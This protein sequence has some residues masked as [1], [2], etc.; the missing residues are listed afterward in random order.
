MSPLPVP[1][2]LD[3]GP[4]SRNNLHKVGIDRLQ[5]STTL[6][7]CCLSALRA[8]HHKRW[9]WGKIFEA[10]PE[11]FEPISLVLKKPL[12]K[13]QTRTCFGG[14]MVYFAASF[15]V[16]AVPAFTPSEASVSHGDKSHSS[17]EPL[18]WFSA[19]VRL[20]WKVL[21]P[22][23]LHQGQRSITRLAEK[24]DILH[25]RQLGKFL[26]LQLFQF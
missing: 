9:H 23:V 3:S 15:L 12:I 17:P 2:S 13:I 21:E 19:A 7:A 24:G 16:C 20:L 5:S 4:S 26:R 6:N 11:P 25:R 1:V 8:L 14:W 22:V 18:W 10:A